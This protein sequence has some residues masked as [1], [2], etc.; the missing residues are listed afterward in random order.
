MNDLFSFFLFPIFFIISSYLFRTSSADNGIGMSH[1]T[2]IEF[3]YRNL[4]ENKVGDV[5]LC[6]G[7]PYSSIEV[8]NRLRAHFSIV[9]DVAGES[10]DDILK[11]AEYHLCSDNF[12]VKLKWGRR[13]WPRSGYLDL[14]KVG[15]I[16]NEYHHNQPT[17]WAEG[18]RYAI[19]EW[20]KDFV[21][22]KGTKWNS[23]VNCQKFAKHVIEKLGLDFPSDVIIAGDVVPVIIDVTT[24]FSRNYCPKSEVS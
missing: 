15:K 22:S 4:Q 24:F 2:D 8:A 14:K 23:D 9:V 1:D 17:Q 12:Q 18:L 5:Y 13:E 20:F 10:T 19:R 21:A 3:G 7:S 16:V 6:L 11:G